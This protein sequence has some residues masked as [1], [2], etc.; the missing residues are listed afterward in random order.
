MLEV[1][2][3]TRVRDVCNS[4]STTLQLASWEGCSLF[5]KI[6]DK[7]RPALQ[8]GTR[9]E[10]GRGSAV[11][12]SFP[13]LL[14]QAPRC[15]MKAG[16]VRDPSSSLTQGQA[17]GKQGLPQGGTLPSRPQWVGRT[18]APGWAA[19]GSSPPE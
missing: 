19:G 4:I 18:Q 8:P 17:P 15:R 10:S 11:C 9:R 16:G 7:V 14:G 5:I 6:A 13:P 1:G 2:S 12:G 3:N